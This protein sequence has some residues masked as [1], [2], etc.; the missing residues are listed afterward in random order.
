MQFRHP[1]TKKKDQQLGDVQQLK[2]N[3]KIVQDSGTRKITNG[4]GEANKEKNISTYNSEKMFGNL[5]QHASISYSTPRT[6]AE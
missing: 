1:K 3:N 6:D 4:A 5:L 2:G